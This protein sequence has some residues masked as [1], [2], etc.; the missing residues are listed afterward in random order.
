M[1]RGDVALSRSRLLSMLCA[2]AVCVAVFGVSSDRVMGLP[3]R[4]VGSRG[5]AL[6]ETGSGSQ[7]ILDLFPELKSLPA[8]LWVQEGLRVYYRTA[9][10]TVP[11][12]MAE[13]GREGTKPPIMHPEELSPVAPALV[14][15]DVIAIDTRFSATASTLF[16]GDLMIP[17]EDLTHTSYAGSG[18]FWINPVVIKNL[19]KR[20]P[21][22]FVVSEV[23]YEAG[24]RTYDCTRFDYR[25][26]G[27]RE[28]H[29]WIFQSSTGLLMYQAQWLTLSDQSLSY[30]SA[31]EFVAK[32]NIS[33]PW[34]A[35]AAPAWVKPG[36]KMT[37]QGAIRTWMP[38]TGPNILIP[39]FL[40]VEIA[41]AG[42]N[43][44][45]DRVRRIFSGDD[46]Q[47]GAAKDVHSGRG[48]IGGFWLPIQGL[49]RLRNGDKLDPFDPIV[50]STVEVSYVGKTH[51]G[52]SVV[53]IFEW[54]SQYKRVW[55]YRAT[56]GKLIYWLD[57]KLVDP[58]TRL[59]QQAEWQLTEE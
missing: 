7:S 30:V 15:T 21:D 31:A 12:P 17:W 8:P 48:R 32:R 4:L 33:L 3:S 24:G 56:D 14:R 55:I 58:V 9:A 49:A 46:G 25:P 59:V 13:S 5:P 19:A 42:R 44:S 35:Y 53:A 16:I 36:A 11:N 2:A 22:Q 47:A 51:S 43:W 52:M 1:I 39:A 41:E 37:Y 20:P 50:G 18:Y 54:G 45:V 10:A 29:V 23:Q 28:H 26:K 6:T 38:T 34:S 27:S 57:E 40:E